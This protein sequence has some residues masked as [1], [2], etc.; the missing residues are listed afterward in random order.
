MPNSSCSSP[1]RAEAYDKLLEKTEFDLALRV[2]QIALAAGGLDI[3]SFDRTE[4]CSAGAEEELTA[5]DAMRA[6]EQDILAQLADTRESLSAVGCNVVQAGTI[7][8][9]KCIDDTH[10]DTGFKKL[11]FI[12]PNG[13]GREIKLSNGTKITCISPEAPIATELTGLE[14]DDEIEIGRERLMQVASID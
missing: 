5:L 8:T 13:G 12:V 10:L 1:N 7:V 2:A 4:P 9:L 3:G 6:N 14:I 11:F